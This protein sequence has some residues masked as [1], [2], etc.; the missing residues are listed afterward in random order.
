MSGCRIFPRYR[1]AVVF[2]REKAEIKS[3]PQ[4]QSRPSTRKGRAGVLAVRY[5]ANGWPDCWQHRYLWR[6]VFQARLARSI[7][8]RTIVTRIIVTR[9]R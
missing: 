4:R 2:Q 3:D 7:V 1:V 5:Q 8:E 6:S 9:E